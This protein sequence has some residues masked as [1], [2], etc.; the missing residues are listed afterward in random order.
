MKASC[1]RVSIVPRAAKSASA[2]AV[3]FLLLFAKFLQT[4]G[5]K[6]E[7][8]RAWDEYIQVVNRSVRKCTTLAQDGDQVRLN[9][10][11]TQRHFHSPR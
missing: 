4:A 2:L 8:L 10:V 5:P 3:L 1:I 11:A 6:A 7:T 9:L